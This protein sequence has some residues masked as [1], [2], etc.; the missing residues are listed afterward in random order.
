MAGVKEPGAGQ[1]SHA[2]FAVLAD[3]L[4]GKSLDFG[5]RETLND[6]TELLL[7]EGLNFC[8]DEVNHNFVVNY[9]NN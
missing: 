2:A 4:E 8:F 7:L 3:F 1:G 5:S 6:P 9:S